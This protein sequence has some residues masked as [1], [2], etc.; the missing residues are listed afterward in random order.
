MILI[1]ECCSL[2]RKKLLRFDTE[3]LQDQLLRERNQSSGQSEDHHHW[4]K[5]GD[6]TG[7][8][9]FCKK[10]QENANTGHFW[11]GEKTWASGG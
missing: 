1:E 11:E 6:N 5:K 10:R 4:Y 3:N 8:G 7:M 2:R 9:Y